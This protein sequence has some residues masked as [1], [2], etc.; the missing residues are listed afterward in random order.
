MLA[1]ELKNAL[2]Q[3]IQEDENI[4]I[5]ATKIMDDL[6]KKYNV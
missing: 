2:D 3:R 1:P 5:P 4:H 6:R